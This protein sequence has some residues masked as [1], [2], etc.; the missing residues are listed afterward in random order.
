MSNRTR[1]ITPE[2][3]YCS[4]REILRSMTALGL[5]PLC[6]P[7]L[8]PGRAPSASDQDPKPTSRPS[9]RGA[10]TRELFSAPEG[11]YPAARNDAFAV[12]ER[13]L[14]DES[15]AVSYNNFYEFSTNKQAVRHLVGKFRT[16]PWKIE[17]AGLV[18]KPGVADLEDFF[19]KLRSEERVYRFRCVE[20]WAMT[21]PWTGFPMKKFLDWVQP[22]PE[23][24]YVRMETFVR[25]DEAPNQKPGS[26]YE[27]P[28]YEALS[29]EEAG[30]ELTLLAHGI[31]G[32]ELPRQNGAPLRLVVP[33]KY[34]LKNIKS[35]VRFEFTKRRPATF[36]ND[37]NPREYS[38][39]SNVDP[40]VPHP[41]WSQ[42]YDR[43]IPNGER[44]KTMPYNGY[45]DEVANLYDD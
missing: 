34:G 38:W 28:Y 6:G 18:E 22:K 13:K 2:D 36:W 10:G 27:W 21:V 24:K 16:A 32:K 19:A 9:P 23:A 39:E 3:A 43:L 33:W 5:V 37:L 42:A 45:A 8:G 14:T 30:H 17:I 31:Y 11:T 40:K 1:E 4:R 41:R 29:L 25:P 44:V 12:P 20:A 26:G 15:A 35:I 7:G